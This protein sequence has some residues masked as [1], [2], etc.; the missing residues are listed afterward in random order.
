MSKPAA[1]LGDLVAHIL[2]PTLAG[3]PGSLNV[4][5]GSSPAWRGVPAAAAAA[6]QSAKTVSD[7]AIKTAEAA[8]VAAAATP[9]A[10]AALA[11]EQTAKTAALKAMGSMISSS[12]GGADIHLCAVPSPVP[13]H[14]P[15][16]VTT[17][18]TTVLINGLPASR[19]G[20]TILEALGPPNAIVGGCPTVLIGG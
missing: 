20:D 16:V 4:I 8:T 11:A 17:G 2:P 6:I 3:S 15:G 1:R 13:P 19:L 10:P 18:S 12:A 5:I 9:G 14:G 7:T